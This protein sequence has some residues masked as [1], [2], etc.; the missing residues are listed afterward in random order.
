VASLAFVVWQARA[1]DAGGCMVVT[2]RAADRCAGAHQ[3]PGTWWSAPAARC[4]PA[5]AAVR[6]HLAHF[7]A[8]SGVLCLVASVLLTRGVDRVKADMDEPTALVARFGHCT[9]SS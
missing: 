9:R 2:A 7:E 5:E 6:A 4:P 3:P 8:A 1:A